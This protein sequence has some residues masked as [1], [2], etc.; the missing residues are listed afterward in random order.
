MRCKSRLSIDEP[1]V[2]QVYQ[3][4]V[5]CQEI[6]PGEWPRN[7]NYYEAPKKVATM[8]EVET[9]FSCA[10]RISHKANCYGESVLGLFVSLTSVSLWN[11]IGVGTCIDKGV[12]LNK[13][14][15]RLPE[16]DATLISQH[17]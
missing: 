9:N 12:S 2:L 6:C 14:Q 4:A 11:D 10:I 3:L 7:I 15:G 8:S 13:R 17:V 16:S 5:M 1:T